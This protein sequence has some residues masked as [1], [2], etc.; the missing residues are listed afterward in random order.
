MHIRESLWLRDQ[1]ALLSDEDLFPLLDIGSSTLAYRTVVQPHVDA[2][3]FAPLRARG[4]ITLHLD[5]KPSDG[6]DIVGDLLDTEF[7][8][9]LERRG[10]RSVLLS[11]VLHHLTD[12]IPLIASVLRLVRPGGHI[13]LSGPYRYPRHY[14]PIDTMFRPTPEEVAA[15]FPGA[16]MV[17][18]AI[19]ESGYILNWSKVER[20]GRSLLRTIVCL[21]LPFYRPWEWFCFVKQAQRIVKLIK[22][23]GVVLRRNEAHSGS[24]RNE[25]L[26]PG[27]PQE[28]IRLIPC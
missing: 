16:S 5:L 28:S 17:A 9:T 25:N 4:G 23:F 15:M 2:N 7:L 21:C 22:A 12:R 6:V 20:G 26:N 3:V 27:S 24:G 13:I 10:V 19:F 11:S 8:A 1:L 18:G 14:D